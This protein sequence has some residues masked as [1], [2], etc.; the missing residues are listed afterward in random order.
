[1]VVRLI[2]VAVV[3]GLFAVAPTWYRRRRRRIER[4]PETTPPVPADLLAGADRTWVLFTTPWCATCGP[5]EEQL[6]AT[7]PGARVVKVDAPRRGECRDRTRA[8]RPC[9]TSAS[10]R[11]SVSPHEGRGGRRAPSRAPR[12]SSRPGAG[13][14][15]CQRRFPPPCP[16]GSPA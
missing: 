14:S 3:I 8:R 13:G 12:T 16:T 1:M 11:R 9:R 15:G 7:D 5:V 10:P 4:G 2:V 6:R